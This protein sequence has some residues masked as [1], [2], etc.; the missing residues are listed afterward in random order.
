M[1]NSEPATQKPGRPE[2]TPSK[3]SWA[4]SVGMSPQ[5][6][7]IGL[8]LAAV[9]IGLTVAFIL[10][11]PDVDRVGNAQFTHTIP[12]GIADDAPGTS[13]ADSA[14]GGQDVPPEAADSLRLVGQ[15]SPG[16]AATFTDTLSIAYELYQGGEELGRHE[17]LIVIPEAPVPN[18][19]LLWLIIIIGALGAS[20]H[21]LTS[22]AD[23]VGSKKFDKAWTIWYLSRPFT[24]ALLA[25][26]FYFV[27]RAGFGLTLTAG[28][29]YGVIAVAGLI[30]L[31]SKQAL[32]KL[33][34]VFDVLFQSNKEERLGGKLNASSVPGLVPL[35]PLTDTR[36]EALGGHTYKLTALGSGFAKGTTLLVE[37][38]AL[39]THLVSATHLIALANDEQW[40]GKTVLRVSVSGASSETEEAAGNANGNADSTTETASTLVEKLNK[41]IAM[42]QAGLAALPA[43]D[44]GPYQTLVTRLQEGVAEVQRMIRAGDEAGAQAAALALFTQFR[45]HNPVRD[46]MARAQDTFERVLGGGTSPLALMEAVLRISM[47]LTG[48]V[49]Q[50]W[51]MR[52]MDAPLPANLLSLARIGAAHGQSAL[53]RTPVLNEAFAGADQAT[54][55]AVVE[56]FLTQETEALAE[57]YQ[58]QFASVEVLKDAVKAF[59]RIAID[60]YLQDQIDR[61]LSDGVES[62]TALVESIDALRAD[63]EAERDLDA[64][65]LVFEALQQSGESIFALFETARADLS[66]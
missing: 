35:P 23:F 2:K 53:E 51:R 27:G 17:E 44:Q 14:E 34:D 29:L 62:Y 47:S 46:T 60:L 5:A 16:L 6:L 4:H 52:L 8:Y 39:E 31:F 54:R 41:G 65:V 21:G 3:E 19:Q 30:G 59:R 57:V 7:G 32:N 25:L 26:I 36:L 42:T 13:A 15:F 33:S 49:K 24:G 18:Q 55:A 63:Q 58:G 10:A 22:L 48:E 66:V 9:T 56:A 64:F 11:F 28:E 20:I 43:E 61:L 50:L 40:E 37:G 38:Q 1:D 45:Q 12:Y